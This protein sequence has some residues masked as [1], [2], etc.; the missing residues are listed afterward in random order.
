M[1]TDGGVHGW[2]QWE[3]HRSITPRNLLI[4]LAVF[5]LLSLSAHNTEMDKALVQ[6]S[7]AV[8][9]AFGIGESQV[10]DGAIRFGSQAFPLVFSQRSPVN[11]LEVF[12][13]N[14]LPPFAYIEVAE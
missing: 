8:L 3:L 12:D 1:S 7:E 10:L 14:D 9:S 2:R 4:A 6:T 5:V 13:G 11:R